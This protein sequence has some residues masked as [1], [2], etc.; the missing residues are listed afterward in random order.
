MASLLYPSYVLVDPV[1]RLVTNATTITLPTPSNTLTFQLQYAAGV[2][3]AAVRLIHWFVPRHGRLQVSAKLVAGQLQRQFEVAATSPQ[4]SPWHRRVLSRPVLSVAGQVRPG[5]LPSGPESD[6]GLSGL[7]IQRAA[8]R[9]CS[10]SPKAPTV[11]VCVWHP[12]TDMG[13]AD[14]HR[15]CCCRRLRGHKMP[16]YYKW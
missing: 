8:L 2:C 4:P 9:G 5:H 16:L 1:G 10:L 13:G 14:G 11:S 3:V 7:V 15:Y 6:G 12:P